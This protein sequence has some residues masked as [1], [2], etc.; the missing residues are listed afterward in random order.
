[1]GKNLL[2]AIGRLGSGH[3]FQV[4]IPNGVGYEEIFRELS[5][6]TLV[7]AGLRRGAVARS[8]WDAW[9]LP[10]IVGGFNPE[11]ILGLGN[12]GLVRPPC[13]QA[14]LCQDAHYF[15]PSSHFGSMTVREK[16]LMQY[17]IAHFRRSLSRSQM[18]L[19]QTDVAMERARNHLNF[20]GRLQLCPNAV[21]DFI[22]HGEDQN[23]TVSPKPSTS[24]LKLLALTRY[25]PHKNLEIIVEAFAR[26][27]HELRDVMVYL[28]IESD[29]HPN[30]GRLL[31][32]IDQLGLSS[33]VKNLGAVEHSGLERLYGQCDALLMP[34][35]LESFSGT[36]LEAMHFG[37]PILTSNLDFAR[38]IC[39][40]AA[41]YF[42]QWDATAIKD[43]ILRLKDRPDLASDLARRGRSR[44]RVS[45]KSWDMIAADVVRSLESLVGR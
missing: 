19:C 9:H 22:G 14:I 40:D 8:T 37:L 28:T 10:R 18:L 29:Q 12:R 27:R 17:Q 34:T 13:R 4:T 15:Y 41:M 3:D 44:L 23:G 35:L 45:S 30:A 25:Y 2:S 33:V 20:R 26:H 32:R 36:Y 42:D 43:A 38:G 39:G 11:V 1:M 5:G 16:V 6:F 21:S 31:R 7:N 24:K